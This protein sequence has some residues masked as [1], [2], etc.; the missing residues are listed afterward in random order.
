M[1]SDVTLEDIQKFREDP[2]EFAKKCVYTLDQV[3]AKNPIKKFPEQLLYLKLYFRIWQRYP[4]IGVPKSRRMFMSWA[5]IIIHLWLAMTTQGR[6]IAFVSKKEDDADELIRKAKF[7]LENIPEKVW[8]KELRPRWEYKYGVL[9]FPEINSK[10]QGFPQGADQLRQFTFSAILGDEMAFWDEAEQM[11]AASFPTLEGGGRFT[12]ISSPGP[13]FFKRLIFDRLGESKEDFTVQTVESDLPRFPM[14]GVE[15]WKNP[16]NKFLIFQLHY[17]ANPVKKEAKYRDTVKAS[18]PIR[19]YMQEYELQ[20]D[21]F[22]G[23]PVFADWDQSVHGSKERITPIN[24]LPLLR[25]WDFG[26]TPACLIAQLQE[27]TLVVLMEIVEVNMGAD[28][29]SDK[30]LKVCK[31]LFPEWH[32]NK[33]NW[34]DFIDASGEFRKDTDEGTCARILDGKGLKCVPGAITWE[35][36]RTAVE[37]FLTRRTKAG[38]CFKVN[39]ATCPILVR[40][41]NGGYRYSESA[42]EIEPNKVRPIKDEHSHIQDSLQMIASKLMSMK[43]R[44]YI[45]VPKPSYSWDRL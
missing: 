7:I 15:I 42:L 45:R 30:V 36:R 10:I 12:A 2:W 39:L 44:S 24:G 41:F 6:N 37:H 26:L 18:M 23:L 20:W 28:R 4:F 5:N 16:K 33:K 22:A 34:L 8:P 32:D 35:D 21:S 9:T 17:S 25:G 14:E 11:Y 1:V 31:T 38:P 19:Q 29:F 13:G 27:D 43:R 3:D 40:G